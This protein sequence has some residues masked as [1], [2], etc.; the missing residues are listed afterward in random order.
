MTCLPNIG[1]E[2]KAAPG[3]IHFQGVSLAQVLDIYQALAGRT[4]I[5]GALPAVQITLHT[6]TP[7][8]RIETLQLL[9]TVLAQNGIAMV[10]A[11]DKTVKAVP[12]AQAILESLPEITLPWRLLPDSSS[13]MTRTVQVQH[14]K[15][16]EV[17]PVLMPFSKLG[18]LIP[19]DGQ[20]SSSCGIIPRTS[21]RSCGCWSSWRKNPSGEHEGRAGPKIVQPIIFFAVSPGLL[22]SPQ[23]IWRI[24]DVIWRYGEQKKNQQGGPIFPAKAIAEESSHSFCTRHR[25][26]LACDRGGQAFSKRCVPKFQRSLSFPAADTGRR[27]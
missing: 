25:H 15:P 6:Q 3:L 8:S 1:P 14:F 7:F 19:M 22:C 26:G 2:E 18:S 27:A 20:H 10:L 24:P 5:H 11:G 23:F 13:V 4:V 21:G 12:A 17:V 16:T 9:D